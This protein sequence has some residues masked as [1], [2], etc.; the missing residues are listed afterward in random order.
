MQPRSIFD[1]VLVA[2]LGTIVYVQLVGPSFSMVRVT[3]LFDVLTN[4]DPAFYLVFAG[5][6]AVVALMYMFVYLPQKQSQ[7][8]TQ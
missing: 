3:M 7:K 1:G 4:L 8:P 6:V 2:I 5:I